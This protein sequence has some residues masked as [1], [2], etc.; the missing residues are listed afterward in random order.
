[1]MAKIIEPCSWSQKIQMCS[2]HWNGFAP[3]P[4]LTEG[5]C[6]RRG[7]APGSGFFVFV[8]R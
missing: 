7:F 1:M 6:G 4:T 3:G 5:G 8:P 2:C